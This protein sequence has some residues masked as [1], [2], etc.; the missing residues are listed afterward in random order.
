MGASVT[1]DVY[2]EAAISPEST[3][4]TSESLNTWKRHCSVTDAYCSPAALATS[5]VGASAAL[6]T[7]LIGDCTA[8]TVAFSDASG[9]AVVGAVPG[10]GDSGADDALQ[11]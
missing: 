5:V 6:T 2:D 9:A 11:L 1:V 10:A 4:S 8:G 7:S 3:T